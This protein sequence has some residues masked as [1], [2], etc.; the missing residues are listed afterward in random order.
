MNATKAS[1]IENQFGPPSE[2]VNVAQFIRSTSQVLSLHDHPPEIA[3]QCSIADIR[4][5]L[6]AVANNAHLM[7]HLIKN[8]ELAVSNLHMAAG[9]TARSR[10]RPP[11][12]D[13]SNDTPQIVKFQEELDAIPL[14][15]WKLQPNSAIF[16]RPVKTSDQNTLSHEKKTRTD[17]GRLLPDTPQAVITVTVHNKLSWRQTHVSRSSRHVI[18]SSQT[19]GDLFESIPCTTN[20]ITDEI[21]DDDRVT[22]YR[23]DV[24]TRPGCVICIEGLAYGDGESELDYAD[25]LIQH[26]QTIPKESANI[27]K[28]PTSMH[29]TPLSSLSLRIGEPYW[30]LHHGNCE[31]FIVVE[32]IRLQHPSDTPSGYPLTTQITPPI[33]DLCRGCTKVP[34]VFSIV[35]DERLGETPCPMCVPCWT[36][37]GDPQNDKVVVVPFSKYELGW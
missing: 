10:K 2:L 26:L 24:P 23:N 3:D 27:T 36:A 30:L 35:N 31:H 6:T 15:S 8:H 12:R 25:K 29:D 4:D 16:I 21:L 33:L 22:A 13:T 32:Q 11:A 18:L 34:A 9:R 19:L 17:D 1:Y 37:M 7:A 14:E 5:S 28:A 20:E